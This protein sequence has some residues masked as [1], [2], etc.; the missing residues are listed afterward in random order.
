MKIFA[1]LDIDND[2]DVTEEEF[3]Q[4]CL[5]DEELVIVNIILAI[6][7]ISSDHWSLTSKVSP[8]SR[9]TS[10]PRLNHTNYS[11]EGGGSQ[12]RQ[13]KATTGSTQQRDHAQKEKVRVYVAISIVII[14][15]ITIGNIFAPYVVPTLIFPSICICLLC[16]QRRTQLFSK[17]FRNSTIAL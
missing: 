10:P 14:I 15:I 7:M 8:T 9:S 17:H 13:D 4:G 12:R 3:V 5:K 2:G 6:N 11:I 1:T 16:Y